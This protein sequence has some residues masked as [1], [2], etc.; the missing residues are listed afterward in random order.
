MMGSSHA[1]TGAGVWIAATATAVPALGV[2]PLGPIEVVVGALICAGAALLPD[3]DHPSA[4]IAH[5][6]P[7]GSIATGMLG[8]LSGGHRKG[9]HSLLAV[10]VVVFGVPLL[11]LLSVE[12]DRWPHTLPVGSLVAVLVCLAFAL[13]AL[14]IARSWL[15]AWILGALLS[16]MALLVPGVLEWLPM[17]IALGYLTHLAG[18]LLT[19]G[20]VPLLWPLM[21][22]PPGVVEKLPIVSR[23]WLSHGAFALPVLGDTGSFREW[24]LTIPVTAYVVWGMGATAIAAIGP[25]LN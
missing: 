4:T 23:T 21:P 16:S 25:I 15:L 19:S 18:D 1:I 17:C 6:L 13:K 7:G 11:S 24:A 12:I 22:S 8:A 20:G 10:L 2:L 14:R 5:S 9:M 3:A